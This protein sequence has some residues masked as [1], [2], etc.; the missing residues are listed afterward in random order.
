MKTKSTPQ[1]KAAPK[2]QIRKPQL[3]TLVDGTQHMQE[4]GKQIVTKPVYQEKVKDIEDEAKPK[5]KA[6]KHKYP[7][8]K[9]HPIFRAKWMSFID[10]ITDRE[11]FKSFHLYLLEILCDLYVEY[12]VLSRV[13]RTEGRTWKSISR[14]GETLKTR[15]E[16]GQMDR[17][18]AEIRTYTRQLDLA[19]KKDNS[20]QVS[21]SEEESWG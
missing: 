21:D 10:N 3:V 1:S 6:S 11:S 8:P 7:P 17:V 19:P 13:L 16:V 15:P 18:L 4:Y 9:N 5:D 20:Y 12:D 14:F 2:K